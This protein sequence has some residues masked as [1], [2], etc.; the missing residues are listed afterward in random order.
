M[1]MLRYICG[2]EEGRVE[3]NGSVVADA[4]VVRVSG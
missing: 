3:S 1:S 4:D 2:G